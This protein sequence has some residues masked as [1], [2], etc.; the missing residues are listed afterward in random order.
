MGSLKALNIQVWFRKGQVGL[1]SQEPSSRSGDQD[2]CIVDV[3]LART[4]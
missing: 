4:A 1:K 2:C 3:C